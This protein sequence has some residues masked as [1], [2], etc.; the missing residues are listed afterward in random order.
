[1]TIKDLDTETLN[2]LCKNRCIKTCP[3]WLTHLKPYDCQDS[4]L[5]LLYY[6]L[7][8]YDND[9]RKELDLRKQE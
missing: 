4:Q 6:L 8:S 5:R 1:M 3:S 2:K 7:D 9:I